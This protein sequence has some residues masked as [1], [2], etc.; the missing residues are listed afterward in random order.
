MNSNNLNLVDNEIVQLTKTKP[1]ADGEEMLVV[2]ED[3]VKAV[4]GN[5]EYK[6][7]YV[8][9][10]TIAGPTR[11]GKSFLFSLLWQFL[12]QGIR[13]GD[14]YEQWSSNRE[15]VQ[16]IF[17]WRNS[18]KSC[19]KGI[20]ILKKP[21]IYVK[22]GMKTALFL[23]DTQGSFDHDASER[24][25]NFLGTF[26]FLLSSYVF[27]NVD[28]S[29]KTT[30]LQS[31]Y[32]S[33]KNLRGGD[34]LFTTQKESL[35]FVVRDWIHVG[36]DDDSDDDGDHQDFA[37]GTDGGKKYFEA[38]IEDSPN[39]A[40]EHQ[41]MQEFLEYAFGK[42]IP[43]CL[44]PHPGNKVGGRNCSVAELSEDFRHESFKFFL[45][46]E[47][48]NKFKIKKI[49]EPFCKCGE[50][51]EAI[52]DYVSQLGDHLDVTDRDSFL[53]KDFRVKMSRHVKN[54]VKDFVENLSQNHDK[55]TSKDIGTMAANLEKMKPPSKAKLRKVAGEF[56]RPNVIDQW[57]EELDRVLSQ[58]ITNLKTCMQV[59]EAYKKAI[60]AYS[61]WHKRS[62]KSLLEEA[63]YVQNQPKKERDSLL[64]EMKNS[65]RLN[66]EQTEQLEDVIEQCERWFLT[67]TNKLTAKVDADIEDYLHKLKIMQTSLRL[68]VALGS[69]IVRSGIF[70]TSQIRA[71][72]DVAAIAL[73]GVD[74]IDSAENVAAALA[75]KAGEEAAKAVYTN[76][77]KE[78]AEVKIL[79]SS[80]KL[81]EYKDGKMTVEFSFGKVIEFKLEV[82]ENLDN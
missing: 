53:T 16:K 25:Q 79:D 18:A 78:K 46:I 39:R 34:G 82:R 54:C 32:K 28:K 48:E 3:A 29:I 31:I 2:D 50:L 43:C 24:N 10:Y 44:L 68:V 63:R 5:P 9:I 4:L 23:M 72:A 59:E 69:L 47:N 45:T 41:M 52:K 37:Y 14:D 71:V 20:S 55:W 36:S 19:T 33:A 74:G 57:E 62:A 40:T 58:V 66:A 42:N 11:S 51:Y 22:N 30:H 12:Q 81:Q 27:F 75:I 73:P 61:K 76:K 56:Y 7:H 80:P 1:S 6:D 70:L 38:L 67:D 13:Q 21:I 65:I 77:L 26:S 64:K 60:L 15:R 35:M 49:Q 8:A 17:S